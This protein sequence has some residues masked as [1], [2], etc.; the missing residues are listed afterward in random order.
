[1]AA[2]T[3]DVKAGGA[4]LEVTATTQPLQ[5]ALSEADNKMEVFVE[6][7]TDMFDDLASS[8]SAKTKKIGKALR[9]DMS[10]GFDHLQ[11]VIETSAEAIEEKLNAINDMLVSMAGKTQKQM[12]TTTKGLGGAF[13]KSFIAL[14]VGIG[15]A[16]KAYQTFS[17]AAR[18][19]MDRLRNSGRRLR[20]GA[21]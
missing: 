11:D 17:Q 16:K 19:T 8:I 10:E 7:A 21:V 18:D 14:S 12:T 9:E 2:N 4:Y 5:E 6:Y 1:M 20:A 13:A 15:A 3:S